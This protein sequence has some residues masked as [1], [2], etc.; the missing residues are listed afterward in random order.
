MVRTY[1][2]TYLG[3]FAHR[4]VLVRVLELH[5]DLTPL[6]RTTPTNDSLDDPTGIVSE[7]DIFDVTTDNIHEIGNVFLPLGAN[8][9]FPGEAPYTFRVL[10]QCRVGF[11]SLAL[12]QENFL[13]LVRFPCS[14]D[15]LSI[16]IK[17]RSKG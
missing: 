15:V 13:C 7:D 5:S 1:G 14:W 6:G 4:Q 3:I 12:V 17:S 9:L 10:E 11:R 2:G 8:V 16:S